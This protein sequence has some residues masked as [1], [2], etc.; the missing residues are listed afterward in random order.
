MKKL[1]LLT[2]LLAG[3][4]TVVP[5]TQNWPDPPATQALQACP[6]KL[7]ELPPDTQLS[8]VAQT[9]SNNYSEYW[10]CAV[11]LDA[12]IEWY[13]KHKIIYKGLQK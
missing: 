8:Q 3:C 9:V 4:S 13:E 1:L 2:L 10:T 6:L 5:V 7:Q 12:W 11:K